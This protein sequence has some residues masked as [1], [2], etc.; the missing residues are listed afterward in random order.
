MQRIF[1]L[2]FFI[3]LLSITLVNGQN[4]AL[5]DTIQKSALSNANSNVFIR[6]IVLSGN[7]KTR[8]YIILRDLAIQEGQ[9]IT[10]KTLQNRL[11]LS[12]INLINSRLYIDVNI[13][14][15]IISKDTVDIHINVKERW[16][17]FPIPYLQYVDRN[18]SQWFFEHK[19]SLDRLNYGIDYTQYNFTGRNDKLSVSLIGGYAQQL[20]FQYTLPFFDKKLRGGT[21][22]GASYFNTRE[23]NYTS[24]LNKQVFYKQDN[25]SIREQTRINLGYSYRRVIKAQH[26]VNIA[27]IKEHVADTILALNPNYLSGANHGIIFPELFYNF[28]YIDADYI[29]YPLHG[30]VVDL[31]FLKRGISSS[32][33]LWQ[34]S[35]NA[36][37]SWPVLWP[38]FYLRM[39]AAGTLSLPFDQ[40]YY[41]QKLFG[42]G[43][44]NLRGL[45]Y[46]VIDGVAGSMLKTSLQREMFSFRIHNKIFA[47][48]K[49][50]YIP[51]KIF[52]KTFTDIGYVYQ[53]QTT[54]DKLSN[55]LLYTGGV[56]VDIITFY[57]VVASINYAL[58]QLGE[59]GIFFNYGV[60]F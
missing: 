42:Y 6:Y 46:Y 45:E 48:K 2:Y 10:K 7:K 49:H 26:T 40:P 31:S 51:F 25:T 13:I 28:R 34:L 38:K 20:S 56:G 35:F 47:R 27:I 36:K 37:R 4:T 21:S 12:K 33:N 19:A 41:N 50:D 9:Q 60:S 24:N 43:D 14:D 11:T 32:I 59:Q 29:S 58:N 16:Y 3:F 44:L 15:T 18:F 22:I 39:Q 30:G 52:L 8:N 5:I 17:I 57:D 55:R 23:L 53:K 54:N 1:F